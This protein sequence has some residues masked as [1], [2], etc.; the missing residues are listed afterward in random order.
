[1]TELPNIPEFSK[2]ELPTELQEVILDSEVDIQPM[3]HELD[4]ELLAEQ[5]AKFDAQGKQ[6]DRR[7]LKKMDQLQYLKSLYDEKDTRKNN[8]K[9]IKKRSRYYKSAIYE[10]KTLDK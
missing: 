4:E 9:K 5:K 7:L 6:L 10:V 8:W 3:I 2:E 1:M